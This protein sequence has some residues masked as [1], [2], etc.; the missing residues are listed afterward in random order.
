MSLVRSLFL[1]V[2]LLLTASLQAHPEWKE[3]YC[4][5]VIDDEYVFD[6]KVKFDAPSFYVGKHP[7][8]ATIK[9]L[10]ALMYEPGRLAAAAAQAPKDFLRG[11]RVYADGVAVPLE[12]VGFPT[13]AEVQ[14]LSKQQGEADRYPV[15]MTARLRAKIPRE[16]GIV[17]V[18]YP[19]ALGSV[20]TNLRRGMDSQVLMTVAPGEKGLFKIGEVHFTLSGFLREGFEHVI[21]DGWDHCLF[22][23]AMM[24]AAASVGEALRRSLV[25]TLGHAITLTLVITG[26]IPPVGNWIEPIIAATI[27]LGGYLAYRQK[28]A[29]TAFVVVPL[30]FGLIHGLGFAAAAADKLQGIGP[31]D[32]AKLLLGF[33]V[34]VEAAQAVIIL[35]TAGILY[36]LSKARLETSALRRIL[37]LLIAIAG[38]AIMAARTWSLTKGA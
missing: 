11:T 28:P 35:T 3:A 17:E 14:T 19:D 23:L 34:G 32:L 15:I 33:N 31:A 4:I 29:Q 2:F 13:A 7:K 22:M 18:V 5:G 37:G 30:V 36:A 9:E 24:L 20:I 6:F 16:T 21:P 8:E 26:T 10:D 25:F 27:A 12:L 38:T 1:A